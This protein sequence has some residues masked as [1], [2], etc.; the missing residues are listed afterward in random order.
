M[1]PF[2]FRNGTDSIGEVQR[3]LEIPEGIL[4]LEM[5]VFDDFPIGA[6]LLLEIFE[7]LAL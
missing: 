4:L 6:Q 2:L 7:G 1:M 3:L 5:M